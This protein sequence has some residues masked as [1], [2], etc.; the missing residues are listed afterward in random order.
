M[1]IYGGQTLSQVFSC[2]NF[3]CITSLTLG[4]MLLVLDEI[5]EAQSPRILV[6]ARAYVD[7]FISNPNSLGEWTGSSGNVPAHTRDTWVPQL[8]FLKGQVPAGAGGSWPVIGRH[9]VWLAVR[10]GGGWEGQWRLINNAAVCSEGR[11]GKEE[12]EN[13]LC[14]LFGIKWYQKNYRHPNNLARQPAE[15]GN[16]HDFHALSHNIYYIFLCF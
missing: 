14:L 1:S 11:E 15:Q 12:E 5:T 6:E 3:H 10:G 16:T 13:P 7:K 2:P 9:H 4:Y 8:S